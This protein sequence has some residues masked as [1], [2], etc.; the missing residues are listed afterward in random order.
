MSILIVDDS[1]FN[2]LYIRNVLVGAGYNNIQTVSSA[3]EA[4]KILGIADGNVPRRP[5]PVA[6]ILLD[7]EMPEMDGI[8]ACKI[9]KE[10]PIYSDLPVIFLTGKRGHLKEAFNAGGTDFIERGRPEYELLARVKSALHLKRE[11]DIRKNRENRLRKELQL[12]KHLQKSVLSSPI[13]DRNLQINAKYIQS[14][15]VS[16]DMFFWTRIDDQKY[17]VLLMDVSGHG[18]SSALISMSVR[19][20]LEEVIVRLVEP[21]LVCEELNKLLLNLFKNSK[22]TVYFT[23]IYLL[24]DYHANLI[25]YFNA[26][27]PPGVIFTNEGEPFHLEVTT[28]PIGIKKEIN[29]AKKSWLIQKPS[30]VLLYTDGLVEIPGSSIKQGILQLEEHAM[31]VQNLPNARFLDEIEGFV[32]HN[33]DDV[34]IISVHLKSR[35]P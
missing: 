26:G 28:I 27:H 32:T 8:A 12:A 7:I 6:L 13:D 30:K 11:T 23:A 3:H 16:G 4:F 20:L 18:L 15:E 5:A 19:S 9:I 22:H 33:R 1:N 24:I 10:H 34:C 14:E 21:S 29:S 17:G 25:E 35:E 31:A 2:L